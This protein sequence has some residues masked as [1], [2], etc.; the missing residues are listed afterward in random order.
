[1]DLTRVHAAQWRP[2]LA[3]ARG[4][5]LDVRGYPADAGAEVLPHLMRARGDSTDRWMH[6]PRF[7]RPFGEMAN[8][9]A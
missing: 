9:K 3:A 7:T 8:G 1:V 4:V 5:V 2:M 6:V